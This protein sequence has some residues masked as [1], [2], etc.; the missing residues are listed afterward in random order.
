M[1]LGG[2]ALMRNN[3]AGGWVLRSTD[4]RRMERAGEVELRGRVGGRCGRGAERRRW[5]EQSR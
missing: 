2:E 1:L 4:V 3:G 5:L